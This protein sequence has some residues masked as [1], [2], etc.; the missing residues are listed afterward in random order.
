[1][2][3]QDSVPDFSSSRRFARPADPIVPDLVAPG[4]AVVS[5]KPGG[6]YQEMDGTSMATPHIAGLAALSIQADPTATI[7]QIEKA[8][9]DSCSPL[10]GES[11]DRQNRGVP[12]A[13]KVLSL[14]PTP[15][16]AALAAPV[17]PAPKRVSKPSRRSAGKTQA[18]NVTRSHATAKAR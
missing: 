8:I 3:Q 17:K 10:G 12:D 11:A 13:L 15:P 2:D 5:A 6:G 14:L 9:F 1:M 4:V 7:D 18:A 16:A